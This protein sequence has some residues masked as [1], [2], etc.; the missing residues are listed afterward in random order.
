MTRGAVGEEQRSTRPQRAWVP[1]GWLV[2][3]Y[4]LYLFLRPNLSRR[5]G[6][7][8]ERGGRHRKYWVSPNHPT[9]LPTRRQPLTKDKRARRR[10][11][12]A[13][14]VLRATRSQGGNTFR[15]TPLRPRAPRRQAPPIEFHASL[16][17][18]IP[19]F[20]EIRRGPRRHIQRVTEIAN[21]SG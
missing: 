4:W 11:L 16:A 14:S 5:R 6:D 9:A 17:R 7:A 2:D 20:L 8:N 15:V 1:W 18:H 12:L 10:R 21:P 3:L 19:H 13:R